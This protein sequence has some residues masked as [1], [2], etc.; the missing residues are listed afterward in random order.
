MDTKAENTDE[1]VSSCEVGGI[2]QDMM[3]KLYRI[4]S[5]PN[6]FHLFV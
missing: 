2:L 6:H 5:I 3:N 1:K 4:Q